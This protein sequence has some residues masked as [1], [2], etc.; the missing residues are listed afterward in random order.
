MAARHPVCQKHTGD[1]PPSI[2][3]HHRLASLQNF[4]ASKIPKGGTDVDSLF[5]LLFLLITTDT[6]IHQN[7]AGFL[8]RRFSFAW[9]PAWQPSAVTGLQDCDDH[10]SEVEQHLQHRKEVQSARFDGT[11]QRWVVLQPPAFTSYIS[12]MAFIRIRIVALFFKEKPVNTWL[13][14]I[15]AIF[16]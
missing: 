13:I 5:S 3:L 11:I 1:L 8:Y 9:D 4:P 6:K 7:P 15:S 2:S 16:F 12:I 10:V 14:V